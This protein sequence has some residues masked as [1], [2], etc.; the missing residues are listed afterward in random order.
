MHYNQKRQE[1][2]VKGHR[3]EFL[4]LVFPTFGHLECYIPP[5]LHVIL[6]FLVE[7]K[8]FHFSKRAL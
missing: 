1:S 6:Q 2:P 8:A 4:P 3:C 7:T 5:C